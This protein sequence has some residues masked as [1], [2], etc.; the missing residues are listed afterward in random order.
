MVAMQGTAFVEVERR[1]AVW[2]DR[3]R[4]YRV[5][6][7]GAEVGAVAEGATWAGQIPPGR[8]RLYLKVDWCRS[9]AVDFEVGAGERA[10]FVCAPS[11]AAWR[12]VYDVTFGRRRYI[13][14]KQRS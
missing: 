7:D 1:P 11:G 13:S 2:R 14:I 3:L 4:E 12:A 8:H 5:I 10:Q 9:T 6:V